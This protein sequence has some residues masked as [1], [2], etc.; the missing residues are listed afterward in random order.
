M[1]ELGR[2]GDTKTTSLEGFKFG[3]GVRGIERGSDQGLGTRRWGLRDQ[4][5]LTLQLVLVKLDLWKKR[6][7][8][9]DDRAHSISL[10]HSSQPT[11]IHFWGG[12]QRDQAGSPAT[13]VPF[14]ALDLGRIPR[15]G[16]M[17]GRVSWEQ[18]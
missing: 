10:Q 17:G 14:P 15:G 1:L 16:I 12:A 4:L 9:R 6:A 8:E 3:T 13:S 2:T 7:G 18:G 5:L 11:G